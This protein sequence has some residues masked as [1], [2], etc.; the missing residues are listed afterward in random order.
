M[1]NLGF[2]E[3]DENYFNYKSLFLLE[4]SLPYFVLFLFSSCALGPQ[5]MQL[6]LLHLESKFIK[7]RFDSTGEL[8]VHCNTM[9]MLSEAHRE[10]KVG[11]KLKGM[12]SYLILK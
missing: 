2:T 11:Q 7:L 1:P 3:E 12:R 8:S 4:N 5:V 6:G 9:S 10:S